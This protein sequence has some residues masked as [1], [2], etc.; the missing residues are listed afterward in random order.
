LNFEV[1]LINTIQKVNDL[2][3]K[4]YPLSALKGAKAP[5]AFFL[6]SEGLPD[7]TLDGYGDTKAIEVELSIVHSSYDGMKRLTRLVMNEIAQCEAGLMGS[8]QVNE[9]TY[10]TPAELY[11][12][13][14]EMYRCVIDYKFYV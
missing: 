11:E 6:S 5:Y 4:V 3:N 1:D 7:R 2:K 12:K 8:T 10:E 9:I 14:V 13:Q